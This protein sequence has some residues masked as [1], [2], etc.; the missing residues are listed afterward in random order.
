MGSVGS[1]CLEVYK[2]LQ[3]EAEAVRT[4]GEEA[5]EVSLAEGHDAR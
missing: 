1:A 3:A 4:A 2:V 5:V